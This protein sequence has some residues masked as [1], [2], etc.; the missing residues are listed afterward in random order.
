MKNL[1]CLVFVFHFLCCFAQETTI[2]R[3]NVKATPLQLLFL[4]IHL[5]PANKIEYSLNKTYV[6]IT[7]KLGFQVG[8]AF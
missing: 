3:W 7:S 5:I 4:S 2:R 8:V 1:L 6:G